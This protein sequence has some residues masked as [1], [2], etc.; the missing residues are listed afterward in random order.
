MSTL[1]EYLAEIYKNHRQQLFTCALAVTRCPEKAE[2]AVHDAFCC[3]FRLRR[4]P[5]SLKA[6]VFRAVRNAAID[7][8]RKN[9]SLPFDNI[10]LV[11]N[12]NDNP[13]ETTARNEENQQL[14]QALAF[15]SNNERETIIHHIY[16]ELTFREIAL[17]LNIDQKNVGYS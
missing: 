10:N 7:Q 8:I 3:L 5:R 16:G 4:I 9:S 11:F 14:M 17:I 15:L 2:D 6:Y 12:L 1:Q 13:H